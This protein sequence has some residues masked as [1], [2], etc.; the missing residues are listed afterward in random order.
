MSKL[1]ELLDRIAK[2]EA[3]ADVEAAEVKEMR[4]AFAELKTNFAE[5]KATNEELR[6]IVEGLP[7]PEEDLSPAYAALDRLDSK[8]DAIHTPEPQPPVE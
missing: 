1:N 4:T 5:L 3:K 6:G 7:L 8:I 2:S